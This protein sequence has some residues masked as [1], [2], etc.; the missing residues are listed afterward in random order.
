M[1][2]LPCK[3]YLE[4]IVGKMGFLILNF[5]MQQFDLTTRVVN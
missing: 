2:R 1:N 4:D 5:S 3:D